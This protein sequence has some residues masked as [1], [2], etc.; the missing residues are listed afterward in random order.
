MIP[1]AGLSAPD[2]SRPPSPKTGLDNATETAR[3]IVGRVD[4]DLDPMAEKGRQGE[5]WLVVGQSEIT[6]WAFPD[7]A[8]RSRRLTLSPGS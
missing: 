5:T 4:T 1:E 3:R 6:E 7:Q 2:Q 8:G